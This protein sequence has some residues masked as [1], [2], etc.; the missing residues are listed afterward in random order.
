MQLL[1]WLWN[2]KYDNKGE[3]YFVQRGSDKLV[4]KD[5]SDYGLLNGVCCYL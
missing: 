4:L 1:F 3:K 2:V 5:I